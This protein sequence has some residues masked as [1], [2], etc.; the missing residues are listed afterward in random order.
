MKI[1]EEK[2]NNFITGTIEINEDNSQK[3]IINSFENV[4][5]KE[6]SKINWNKIN[7]EENEKEIKECEIFINNQKI[8]FDYF[9]EFPKKGN[10]TIKYVFNGLLKITNCMF[11]GCDSLKSLDLSNFNTEKV[12]NMA[13]M[14]S[15]CKSLITLNLIM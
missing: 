10:Y 15:K 9:Y 7:A 4:Q 11:F 13:C 5:K 3:L 6:G 12:I 1:V 8:N 2:K 14:F